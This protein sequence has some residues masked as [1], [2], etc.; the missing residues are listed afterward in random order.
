MVLTI[1]KQ[2]AK[3]SVMT[4]SS[5]LSIFGS[6]CIIY[7]NLADYCRSSSRQSRGNHPNKKKKKKLHH[8]YHRLIFVLSCYDII[9]S[10]SALLQPWLAN[11]ELYNPVSLIPTFGNDI[12]CTIIGFIFTTAHLSVSLTNCFLSISFKLSIVNGIT[13]RA[14]V[15]KKY[16]MVWYLMI[17]LVPLLIGI[18]TIYYRGYNLER[19]AKV[20]NFEN[21][22]PE[23]TNDMEWFYL[24]LIWIAIE[25][26]SSITGFVSAYQVYK[27][28]KHQTTTMIQKYDFESQLLNMTKSA[29]NLSTTNHAGMLSSTTT[30]TGF[31]ANNNSAQQQQQAQQRIVVEEEETEED[32]D[33]FHNA[34]RDILNGMEREEEE[35]SSTNITKTN[36]DSG[37][38][39]VTHQNEENCIIQQQQQQQE[40]FTSSPQHDEQQQQQQ[41]RQKPAERR[42]SILSSIFV[43]PQVR[44]ISQTRLDHNQDPTVRHD[45]H[46]NHYYVNEVGIQVV[47]YSLAYLNSMIW[48]FLVA[49]FAII[50][51]PETGQMYGLDLLSSTFFPLQGFLNF[52]IY[53]RP[54]YKQYKRRCIT[55]DSKNNN[56][57]SCASWMRII[58]MIIL[59]P[60]SLDWNGE[61]DG[62]SK[63]SPPASQ[64]IAEIQ[65]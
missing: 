48:P 65:Q 41:Q 7:I 1:A 11:A 37:S 49:I 53:I 52:F 47:L 28:V 61:G 3:T 64:P 42:N 45:H 2:V 40:V 23:T 44:Q 34:A 59:Q 5:L 38:V 33:I 16:E 54:T 24:G 43:L 51:A 12:S 27:K 17:V 14:I 60:S 36:G 9:F 58:R 35:L 50:L 31:T 25:I 15:A 19:F 13:E 56:N 46:R 55:L 63:Q 57:K 29:N 20:C 62:S 22:D 8:L 30:T 6:G 26:V 39:I 10:T 21:P 4:I 18:L 32:D